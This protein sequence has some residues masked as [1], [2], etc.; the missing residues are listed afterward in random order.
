MT[1]NYDKK[2][3]KIRLVKIRNFLWPE[4][5]D[6]KW[7]SSAL[8]TTELHRQCERRGIYNM[9]IT[10]QAKTNTATIWLIVSG[11]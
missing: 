9:I 5:Q 3:S 10:L 8:F 2:C 11:V 4:I 1:E 6:A 7:R